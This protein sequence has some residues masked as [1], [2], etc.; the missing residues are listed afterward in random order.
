ME[1]IVSQAKAVMSCAES[2]V[3]IL[4]FSTSAT[5]QLHYLITFEFLQHAA[6]REV[7]SQL[8]VQ[9]QEVAILAKQVHLEL[10]L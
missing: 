9:L 1:V 7:G 8:M 4:V 6:G 10:P 3:P 2:P 5:V